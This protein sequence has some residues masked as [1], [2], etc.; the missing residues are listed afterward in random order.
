MWWRLHEATLLIPVVRLLTKT[1]VTTCDVYHS[2]LHL[3]RETQQSNPHRWWTKNPGR[4]WPG[5]GKTEI[6]QL[7]ILPDSWTSLETRPRMTNKKW[8]II[9]QHTKIDQGENWVVF[10][11]I[12]FLTNEG[13]SSGRLEHV[14]AVF[15][16]SFRENRHHLRLTKNN[17]DQQSTATAASHTAH[18]CGKLV[19]RGKGPKLAMHLCEWSWLQPM[20]LMPMTLE[21]KQHTCSQCWQWHIAKTMTMMAMTKSKPGKR[22][23]LWAVQYNPTNITQF[24]FEYEQSNVANILSIYICK[25]ICKYTSKYI[26]IYM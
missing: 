8:L 21:Q 23:K 4:R 6:K 22:Q 18:R 16:I 14:P 24:V 26:H 10:K 25:Y 1:Q 7:L 13:W 15:A 11:K 19:A 17:N 3:A 2:P 12:V 9:H 20:M 5:K